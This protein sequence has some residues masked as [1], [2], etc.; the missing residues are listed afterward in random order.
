MSNLPL[1]VHGPLSVRRMAVVLVREGWNPIPE[2]TTAFT[3]EANFAYRLREVLSAAFDAGA[4]YAAKNPAVMNRQPVALTLEELSALPDFVGD[5]FAAWV[6]SR[7]D[8]VQSSFGLSDET[9]AGYF[10]KAP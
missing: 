7:S 9:V 5:E 3:L 2:P 1:P 4:R 8:Q 6:A 10:P